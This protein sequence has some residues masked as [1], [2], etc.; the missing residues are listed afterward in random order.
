MAFSADWFDWPALPDL[1]PVRYHGVL[2]NRDAFLIDIDIERLRARI[3][4]YFDSKLTHGEVERRHPSALKSTAGFDARAG[5]AE[6][7]AR[8]G[9]AEDG[10]LRI[11]YRPFDNRWLYWEGQTKLLDRKRRST[12]LTC[13]KVIS[14]C[15]RPATAPRGDRAANA[16]TELMGSHHL[17]ER[18]AHMFPAWLRDDGIDHQDGI[19]PVA[20]L[21][22]AAGRYLD[23]LG[24]GVEDLFHHILATLHDPDYLSTNSGALRVTWPRIPLPAWPD[25]ESDSAASL[26]LK[27]AAR[28]A[29]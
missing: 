27:S 21:S 8:G 28:A 11:S 29:P 13:S 7:L 6:L 24:L 19:H 5:R 12:S 16:Y 9:P 15:R 10:F 14:G 23:Q 4:D 22:G 1:L 18:G 3:T 26:I 25:G 17:I 2:T 20:N